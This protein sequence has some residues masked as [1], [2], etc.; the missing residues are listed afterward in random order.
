[1]KKLLI[2][3]LVIATIFA[4]KKPKPTPTPLVITKDDYSANY[5]A[6]GTVFK[7]FETSNASVAVPIAGTDQTWDF[8]TL[9]EINANT[10]G[11]ANFL[12]PSNAAFATATYAFIGTT[13]WSAGGNISPAVANT[14][15]V[16]LDNDG[17][18]SLGYSQNV[19]TAISIPSLG[20]TINYPVQNLVYTG[21]IKYPV[22][23][24]P[25]AYG[26]AAV[27]TSGMVFTSNYTVNAPALG[28]SNTP[29]QTKVTSTVIFD[30]IGSGTVNLK[31]IGSV[32]VLLAKSSISDRTNYF[33]GG[34][35][36]PAALLSNLGLTDGAITTFTTYRFVAPGLGSVGIIDVNAMGNVTYANFRKG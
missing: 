11:G 10:T 24:F 27:V 14:A 3:C 19:A 12:A 28:L 4:C 16:T 29:G 32:K 30:V 23:L 2:S 13:S 18:F 15:F 8:S 6:G 5:K 26:G 31:G 17:L 9:A 25:A 20:A 34:A 35:P 1:M 22:F 36:A 7:N 33:L 21:T